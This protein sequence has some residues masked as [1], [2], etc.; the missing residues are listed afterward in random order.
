MLIYIYIHLHTILIL[1]WCRYCF[2]AFTK[3]Y[4]TCLLWDQFIDVKFR[5][6][7]NCWAKNKTQLLMI[8]FLLLPVS[9]MLD[10]RDLFRCPLIAPVYWKWLD[11]WWTETR[12]IRSRNLILIKFAKNLSLVL[13]LSLALFTKYFFP[14]VS[15]CTGRLSFPASFEVTHGY[16]TYFG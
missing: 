16:V 11:P 15:G 14:F 2:P 10:I 3:E 12:W 9:T 8:K 7:V 5:E 6:T 1:L 13:L 4:A